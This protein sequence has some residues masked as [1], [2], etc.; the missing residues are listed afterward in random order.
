MENNRHQPAN[1]RTQKM[2]ALISGAPMGP[3]TRETFHE[4]AQDG[5]A[6]AMSEYF[7]ACARTRPEVGRSIHS[8]G[9]ISFESMYDEVETAYWGK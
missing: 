8:A 1:D 9:G 4:M 7:E 6:D 2:F 5:D 3:T